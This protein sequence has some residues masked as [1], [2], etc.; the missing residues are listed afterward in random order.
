MRSSAIVE[1]PA[2]ADGPCTRVQVGPVQA[3]IPQASGHLWGERTCTRDY[4]CPPMSLS[5]SRVESL[6]ALPVLSRNP[7]RSTDRD[8]DTASAASSL[9]SVAEYTGDNLVLRSG[10]RRTSGRGGHCL[11]LQL[12]WWQVTH[13]YVCTAPWLER[14]LGALEPW[15]LKMINSWFCFAFLMSN[16]L[17]LERRY[18]VNDF[19]L[20]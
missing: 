10:P 8:W 14:V 5:F 19:S 20:F 11:A 9:A 16:K 12:P 7:S 13:L 1:S 6:E 15:T 2:T 17:K 3:G 18:F 4:P